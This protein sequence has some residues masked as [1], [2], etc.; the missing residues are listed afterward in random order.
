MVAVFVAFAGVIC[1]G[2][3]V[4]F[5]T[6]DYPCPLCMIQRYGMMLTAAGAMWVVINA[7]RGTMTS[8]RYSQGIGLSILG[9]IIGGAA[10]V[11]QVLLHIMPGDPGYGD[12]VLGLHLYTWA[13]VC[14]I[15]LIIFCGCLLVIA[16]RARP[17]APAKGGFWWI[18]SSIGI[19]F[20]I[21]VVIA[22][23]IMIIFL[24][25]FAFVLPDDPTSYNLIDQLTGK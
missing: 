12:P 24:E 15:V 23:L 9:A 21:V 19:W 8:S 13:L 10:S 22:N 11:R 18:L 25:G 2:F 16:P 14:F 5:G 6:G 4:Q 1:G 20:F 7:R 3:A 17:I